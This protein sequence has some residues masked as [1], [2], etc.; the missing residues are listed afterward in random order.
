[1]TVTIFI[2]FAIHMKARIKSSSCTAGEMAGG[3][4]HGEALT[5]RSLAPGLLV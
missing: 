2:I 4:R 1:M 3:P 5:C